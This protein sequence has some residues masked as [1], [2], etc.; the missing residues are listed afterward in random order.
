MANFEIVVKKG[1]KV[2][3]A[4]GD[5][6]AMEMTKGHTFDWYDVIEIE[7]KGDSVWNTYT[8]LISGPGYS[9]PIRV[10]FK[11]VYLPEISKTIGQILDTEFDS[12][13]NLRDECFDEGK[14][15]KLEAGTV[16]TTE[17]AFTGKVCSD[18]LT[19]DLALPIQEV[20]FFNSIRRGELCLV[21]EASYSFDLPHDIFEALSVGLRNKVEARIESELIKERQAALKAV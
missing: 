5:F 6:P 7:P 12:V 10:E 3:P 14:L 2:S 4:L 13:R 21:G 9:S 15:I 1:A 20:R 16:L 19:F 18:S 17:N 11:D 8:L